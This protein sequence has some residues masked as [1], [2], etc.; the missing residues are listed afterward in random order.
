VALRFDAS[1]KNTKQSGV[2]FNAFL[3]DGTR[4]VRFEWGKGKQ[5]FTGEFCELRL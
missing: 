3:G 1:P 5:L 4:E 2:S